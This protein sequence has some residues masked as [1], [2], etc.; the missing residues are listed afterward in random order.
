LPSVD[1]WTMTSTGVLA[2]V[3]GADYHMEFVYADGKHFV[4]PKMP[5]DW[6]RLTDDDKQKKLDSARKVID[7]LTT[8]G[9]YKARVC[10]S[11]V[12]EMY[13]GFVPPAAGAAGAGGAGGGGGG[14][15]G[16]DAG[17]GAVAVGRAGGGGGAPDDP[18]TN[19]D[20]HWIPVA[21]QLP[22]PSEIPDYIPPVRANAPKPD[23]DGNI[24]IMPTTSLG[25]KDGILY[26]VVNPKGE[27][28]ERV[29]LPKDRDILAFGKGGV[30]Y[31]S[32]R[33]SGGVFVEKVRVNRN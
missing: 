14:G 21:V 29:Q 6:R 11:R 13:L 20:C 24:W 22:A 23:L 26:D 9:G 33:E 12:S 2:I 3:R 27:V 32:R 25:A 5:F 15:R 28:V 30:L 31:L 4:G 19:L 10:G 8:L 17:G 18:A 16:G 7:S 1:T